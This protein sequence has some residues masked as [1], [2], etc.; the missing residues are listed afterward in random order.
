MTSG[1]EWKEILLFSLPIMAGQF[2][3]QLY[4]TVDGVVVGNYGGATQT[5]CENMIAAVGSCVSLIF[6]FLAISIGLGNGGAVL[7]A[8]LYGA[9]GRRSC[10][11]RPRPCS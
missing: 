1:S 8:Q 10:V 5:I 3:Q 2:L 11:G 4:N 9:V 7:V 6:L